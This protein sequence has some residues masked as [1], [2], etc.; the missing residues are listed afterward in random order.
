MRNDE[1]LPLAVGAGGIF[2]LVLGWLLGSGVLRML[3]LAA[4]L[5]GGGLFARKKLA[6]RGEKIEEAESAIR[7]ELDE[8]DPV[9]Q[10]QVLKG[11]ADSEG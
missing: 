2:A 5:V 1:S 11:L 9:A 8:L 10:A 4:A 7:A 3:G 6:E